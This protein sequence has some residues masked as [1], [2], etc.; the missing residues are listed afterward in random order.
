MADNLKNIESL[1]HFH[2]N[3]IY[4]NVAKSLFKEMQGFGE[5]SRTNKKKLQNKNNQIK[6]NQLI[7]QAFELQKQGNT[8]EAAKYYLYLIRTGLKDYRVFSNYGTFLKEQGKYKEAEI[9]LKKAITLNPEYANAYYNLAGIYIDKGNFQHAEIFLRKAIKFKSNFAIAHYNLGF[10]LK[11]LGKLK[12]AE[13]YTHNALKINPHLSDAYF[14]LSTLKNT[15]KDQKWQ[16][17]LFSENLLKNK[18]SRDL[19][20]IFFARSNILHKNNKY[21]KS[22]ENLIA[23]NNLKLKMHK[24]N[25]S[26]LIK[27]TSELKK[28]LNNIQNNY[29]TSS[30]E[31]KCIF[32]VGL[33]RSGTTLIESILSSNT[34]VTDLGEVNIFEDSYKE[35]IESGYKLNL[36]E[37]YKKHLKKI[38]KQSTITTNKWL[39]NYQYAGIIAKSIP[40]AKIIHCNRNPL[41]NIL[42]IYRAHF[43]NSITFSS[44][45]IDCAEVYS[46]QKEIMKIYKNKFKQQIYDLNYDKL[47]KNPVQ[48]IKSLID[49]LEW[50]WNELYLSPHLNN[51]KV[52]TRS[53]VQVRSPINSQ[54]VGGWKNYKNMLN[55]S[56]EILIKNGN[57]KE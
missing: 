50:D 39:F 3:L 10:I 48:E 37:I 22:A 23:A 12:E 43:F 13:L 5:K 40:N 51:R 27:K 47:V 42:S 52:S 26:F 54:S 49:W 7:K 53:N 18:D 6:T 4:Y 1:I 30:N 55:P 34:Q 9:E 32:I 11:D 41:D 15:I 17:R 36:A 21:Q 35:Y 8:I 20:N 38:N 24:S 29:Q 44:S 46:D 33:P 14:S 25:A 57:Y 28:S 2:G 45:L 31:P 56:I 19:V 16:D